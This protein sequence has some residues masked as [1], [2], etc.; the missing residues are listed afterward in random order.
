EVA[1]A[2]AALGN[3]Q[4]L[5]VLA[6]QISGHCGRKRGRFKPSGSPLCASAALI[7]HHPDRS[8][9]HAILRYGSSGM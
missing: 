8:C 1:P 9:L 6:G 4:C 2:W 5:I 7:L 3:Q